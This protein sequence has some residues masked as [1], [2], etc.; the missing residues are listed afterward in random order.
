MVARYS[1]MAIGCPI[2]CDDYWLPD[3]LRW[4]LVAMLRDRL[5]GCHHSPSQRRLPP[6]LKT[7]NLSRP[8]IR[9]A[10]GKIITGVVK[11]KCGRH[12]LASFCTPDTSCAV[13]GLGASQSLLRTLMVRL[14]GGRCQCGK[15]VM[16]MAMPDGWR[17][18]TTRMCDL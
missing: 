2:F 15:N 5:S 1:A 14:G 10:G 8:P 11:M 17:S 18:A 7:A 9:P 4:I 12:C 13:S 3:I 16:S 6:C